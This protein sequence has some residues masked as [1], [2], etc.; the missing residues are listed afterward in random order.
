MVAV[1]GIAA[2][3]VIYSRLPGARGPKAA[4]SG[5]GPVA[6]SAPVSPPLAKAPFDANQAHIYQDQWAR[7]LKTKVTTKNSIGMSMVLIPPGEFM[8]GSTDEQVEA[9]I[10]H[11]VV[12]KADEYT[13]SRIRDNERPQHQVRITRP[14]LM[15]ATE[16]TIGQFR[17]FVDATKYVTEA[18]QFGFGNSSDRV[19]G[20]KV[21]ETDRG[22]NWKSP[23]YTVTD[24]S[25]VSQVTWNDGVVFC[26]WLSEQEQ[27]ETCYRSDAISGWIF[28][29]QA[30]GYC[31][32]TEAVWEY[33]C[34]AGTTTQYSFGD[35]VT[36]LKQHGW[37]NMSSGGSA[38]AVGLKLVNPWG[39]FDL[40][41]NVREWCQDTYDAKWYEKIGPDNLSDPLNSYAS[42]TRVV[43]GGSWEH[44]QSYCRSASRNSTIASRR[45]ANYG[46]RPVRGADATTAAAT[47]T[48]PTPPVVT[49]PP[50]IQPNGAPQHAKAPFDTAQAHLYQDLWARHL[51]TKVVSNNSIGMSMVLIPPGEFLMGSTDEQV[52]AAL[53]VAEQI[54]ADQGTKDRI[55]KAER[56]QHRVTIT[57]PFLMAETEVTVAEFRQ[58]VEA[59]Q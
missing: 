27:R 31:L 10:V 34:R 32:P 20:D 8:M 38:R 44:Y 52:A 11:A 7:H 51:G 37:Y 21:K 40:H 53:V 29:R 19:A 15:A 5:S 13:V 35:D 1:L 43:R 57:R 58:F 47:A 56:P 18:E 17:K 30:N 26:N 24:D 4:T 2:G 16:V 33:A 28:L 3:V 14:F 25:P 55:Q 36:E 42:S 9:A 41:G 48:K 39:L 6:N 12:E 50:P 23:G 49:S 54:K 22:L 45:D 46:F 59:I